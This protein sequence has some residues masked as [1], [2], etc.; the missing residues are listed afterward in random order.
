MAKKKRRANRR[1]APPKQAKKPAAKQQAPPEPPPELIDARKSRVVPWLAPAA[2]GL[3]ALGVYIGTLARSVPTGDSGELITAAYVGGV[4]HPPGYPIY[5]M[6]GWLATHVLPGS[7]A[8][9]MNALSA[10]AG[11]GAV[12]VLSI[13][14]ARL[15]VPGWPRSDDRASGLVAGLAA[16]ASLALSTIFWTYSLVAE[17]FAL[18]NLF[19]AAI[20]LV[21]IEW[22]R[23]R[24]RVWAL[25]SLGLLSG[26]A[27]AHQQQIIFLAP[28]LLVLLITGLVEESDQQPRRRRA[29]ARKVPTVRFRHFAWA[30]GLIGVGL[31][32]YLYL[33]LAAS[34]DPV[35]NFGDP[36]NADRLWRVLW[37]IDYGDS[38][39]LIPGSERGAYGENLGLY[40]ESLWRSFTPVG[41]ALALAGF[42]YLARRHRVEFW[43]I[44]AAFVTSGPL[45]VLLASSP[46]NTPITE[47]IVERFY[48]LSSVVLA[49]TIGAGVLYSMIGIGLLT[50]LRPA[51]VVT[52]VGVLAVLLYGTLAAIRWDDVDQSDNRVAQN[53]GRD[54]I[55]RLEPDAMLLT[56]GDHNYTSLVHAQYVEGLRPDVAIVEIELLQRD[57]YLEELSARYPAI[58]FP[59]DVYNDNVNSLIDLVEANI[60]D[61][62][63]YLVGPMPVDLIEAVVEVRSG[64]AR[65]V[66]LDEDADQ[67]EA[68]IADPSL[69]TDLD[70]PT[71]TYADKTWEN[72]M[73]RNYGVTAHGLA[74]ALHADAP[75]DDDGLV[76]EMYRLSIDL[77]P[78]PEAYK[79]LG[80]FLFQRNRD[81]AE[82][83]DL[84]ETY[85]SLGPDDPQIPAIQDAI[86]GL[87]AGI[88]AGG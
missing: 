88:A 5:T 16:G 87:K 29:R 22:Y 57:F 45:F 15:L 61:M 41:I 24:S 60:D 79:N 2:L 73:S 14:T 26:L 9:I 10:V 12:V 8:V 38:F 55:K 42:V 34:G 47:G 37:R 27:A 6:L 35:M 1:P 59:W 43:A 58:D 83:V 49:I 19:A 3:A 84:W 50:S 76:E 80:L 74:F 70:Y 67:Y 36:E 39:Q 53:Y 81:A 86:Q 33:P 4:A 66:S 85:I 28:G 51:V 13:L 21:A 82:I 40:L 23:D 11:A 69:A 46:I 77:G 64:L 31:T 54:I 20:L 25:L 52:S 78:P 75:N 32:A 30:V 18:N 65:R 71:E 72:L 44:L 63:I 7:P 68:F 62:P 56:R 17:V 48:M